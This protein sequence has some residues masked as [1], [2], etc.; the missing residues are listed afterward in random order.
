ML[1]KLAEMMESSKVPVSVK[2]ME[3]SSI[4]EAWLS[5]AMPNKALPS[6]LLLLLTLL[7][8][9][10]L[11]RFNLRLLPRELGVF[12]RN[13]PSRCFQGVDGVLPVLEES[14]VPLD[15]LPLEAIVEGDLEAVGVGSMVGVVAE[16]PLA[17]ILLP[18]SHSN[19]AGSSE[20]RNCQKRCT[21]SVRRQRSY[22]VCCAL[23]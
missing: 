9:P 10:L 6:L 8:L 23:S 2:L 1:P 15:W 11:L 3:A 14:I 17:I 21:S 22:N 19:A 20:A 5:S 4:E 16:V 7:L 13:C 12:K 18:V